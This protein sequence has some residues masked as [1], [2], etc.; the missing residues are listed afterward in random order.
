MTEQFEREERYVVVKIKDMTPAQR[1]ALQC[2]L[3]EH[4]T[5]TRECVVVEPDW[6]IYEI[7]W[8]L[9]E[10]LATGQRLPFMTDDDPD[11]LQAQRDA[12]LA[13]AQEG[14]GACFN[15]CDW[16][17]ASIQETGFELG[18]LDE[19][20]FDPDEH[21]G[22]AAECCDPGDTIYVFSELMRSEP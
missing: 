7:V 11:R 6:P 21:S 13:F 16:D 1:V 19:V 18:L 12:L 14:F 5:P 10:R 15:G 22:P 8:H 2:H 20:A 17:G 9:V 4:G 3:E